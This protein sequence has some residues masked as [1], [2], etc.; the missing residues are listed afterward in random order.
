MLK[1]AQTWFNADDTAKLRGAIAE[2]REAADGQRN[3]QPAELILAPSSLPWTTSAT[4]RHR[5]ARRSPPASASLRSSLPG[6]FRH[7]IR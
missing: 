1:P 6:W 7:T 2:S 3:E 4:A 5:P